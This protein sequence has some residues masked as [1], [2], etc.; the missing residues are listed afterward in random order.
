[1]TYVRFIAKGEDRS[2][3]NLK[4]LTCIVLVLTLAAAL[5]PLGV[6]SVPVAAQPEYFSGRIIL[7]VEKPST[8][9]HEY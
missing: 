8:N 7:G 2:I 6:M 4:R 3:R 5:L 1:M 9:V